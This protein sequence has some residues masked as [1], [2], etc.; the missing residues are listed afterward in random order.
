MF[1]D[2]TVWWVCRG[3]AGLPPWQKSGGEGDGAGSSVGWPMI[4]SP[5]GFGKTFLGNV[6]RTPHSQNVVH[7]PLRQSLQA[8]CIFTSIPHDSES[9]GM[10]F[11]LRNTILGNG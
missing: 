7:E 4:R 2:C 10:K 6:S 1:I 8:A 5:T 9:E 11:T 3:K